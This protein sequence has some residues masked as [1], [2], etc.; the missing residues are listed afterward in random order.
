M[1]RT[2]K[3]IVEALCGDPAVQAML[4]N[5][6]GFWAVVIGIPGIYQTEMAVRAVIKNFQHARWGDMDTFVEALQYMICKGDIPIHKESARLPSVQNYGDNIFGSRTVP[7]TLNIA[8]NQ[9]QT[10]FRSYRS[11]E[12]PSTPR[13]DLAQPATP[14]SSHTRLTIPIPSHIDT[15]P[16]RQ[17]AQAAE[18]QRSPTA[19]RPHTRDSLLGA[20]EAMN[21]SFDDSA[22]FSLQHQQN[23][24][25]IV[26]TY[27]KASNIP[28][29]PRTPSLGELPD[30]YLT[31]HGYDLNAICRI[32]EVYETADSAESFASSLASYG[33]PV[34]EA[35]L[36]AQK[37]NKDGSDSNVN[38]SQL[39]KDLAAKWKAMSQAE[40]EEATVGAVE[41]LQEQREIK[42]LSVHNTRLS[43]FHD[44]CANLDA[45][46]DELRALHVR[47]GMQIVMFAIKSTGD[48]YG[49]PRI[50]LTSKHL[51]EFFD[52]SLKSNVNDVT[53]RLKAYCVS[54]AQGKAAG[55][56]V[57]R[58]YYTNFDNHI[59]RV[60]YVV[61]ENWPLQK[62]CR[63]SDISLHNEIELIINAFQSGAAHFRKLTEQEYE[64]WEQKQFQNQMDEMS[65]E[66]IDGVGNTPLPVSPDTMTTSTAP[67]PPAH[68]APSSVAPE[69]ATMPTANDAAL[70]TNGAMLPSLSDAML[71]PSLPGLPVSASPSFLP[72]FSVLDM[73]VAA[74]QHKRPS[75]DENISEP[76]LK[77]RA[78]ALSVSALDG[79]P[80]TSANKLRK[81]RSDKGKKQKPRGATSDSATS[82][83][84]PPPVPSIMQPVTP[85][86]PAVQPFTPPAVQP[87]APSATQPLVPSTVQ[88][89][90]HSVMQPS[91]PSA[92]QPSAPST[93]QSPAPFLAT[94]SAVLNAA[95]TGAL[96]GMDI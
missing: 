52:L 33:F 40:K 81:T 83:P 84:M 43:A 27:T 28:R 54:G 36:E 5:S 86:P 77:K 49:C 87:P 42:A 23:L 19:H 8:D 24:G 91:A 12:L 20:L 63:P 55:I 73:R 65:N 94:T 82:T 22:P 41:E 46:E 74:G 31:S 14:H 92:T 39:A 21:L 75:N 2:N 58:M 9:T 34:A 80:L 88:L 3:E 25:G 7:I 66:G 85:T 96:L 4:S 64:D 53:L 51:A 68:A 18:S 89:S 93:V 30:D 79:T 95:T 26:Y 67:L 37:I 62:F 69:L 61:I 48:Q 44:A 1:S 59:T 10:S 76:A 17:A 16:R 78:A 15:M 6:K 56:Q 29:R 60:Y 71:S 70:A 13:S 45:I 11:E 47:T 35:L 38:S 57:L 72:L 50:F 32:V 90:A